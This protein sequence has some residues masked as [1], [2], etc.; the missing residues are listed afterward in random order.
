MF[1]TGS[2]PWS[3]PPPPAAGHSHTFSLNRR[4]SGQTW[5]HFHISPHPT[6]PDIVLY[7]GEVRLWKTTM[8]TGPWTQSPI[9][10][11]CRYHAF[12]F[13]P[14][15]ANQILVGGDGGVYVSPDAGATT[16]QH[17]NRDLQLLE[18]ISVSHSTVGDR[19]DRRTQDNG[20]ERFSGSPAWEFVDGGDGGFSTAI[21]P[22]DRTVMYHEYI[23]TT[24]YRSDASGALGTWVPQVHGHHL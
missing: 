9:L 23:S 1:E 14:D 15:D 4:L 22:T 24:F 10:H 5:Y 21:K 13:A 17:R 3:S 18:Y 11:T 6:N 2:G 8:G 7:Y 16:F 12:A 20:T 19:D